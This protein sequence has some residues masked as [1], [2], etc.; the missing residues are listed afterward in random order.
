LADG[1][2]FV[3]YASQDQEF[4]DELVRELEAAGNRIWIA[5]RDVR[6]GNYLP[7]LHAAI[8]NAAAF[9][10]IL[11]RAS[12]ESTFV[13]AETEMAFSKK[14]PIFPVRTSPITPSENLALLLQM[15]HWTD[16]FGASRHAAIARLGRELLAVRRGG[17]GGGGGR[18][19][20]PSVEDLAEPDTGP[21]RAGLAL[22]LAGCAALLVCLL[23]VL[24]PGG[25][26]AAANLATASDGNGNAA[27]PVVDSPNMTPV[28]QDIA[29]HSWVEPPEDLYANTMMSFD[30]NVIGPMPAP[31]STPVPVMFGN[32]TN[33]M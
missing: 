13:Q 1:P 12:N 28:A 25:A 11:T 17:R 2:I 15:H 19:A 31:A 23:L 5:P 16:A 9:V 26:P 33:G 14:L 10:V 22:A 21:S 29:N 6:P 18:T 4:A 3:S 7:Q 24:Q 27:P 32:T 8:R 30:A 20:P